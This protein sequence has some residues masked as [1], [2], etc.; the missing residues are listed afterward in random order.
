MAQF[1]HILGRP[2]AAGTTNWRKKQ[3]KQHLTVTHYP[4]WLSTVGV[5]GLGG[6]YSLLLPHNNTQNAPE[7]EQQSVSLSNDFICVN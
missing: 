2:S 1:C 7:I 4:A 5:G 3:T 6:G